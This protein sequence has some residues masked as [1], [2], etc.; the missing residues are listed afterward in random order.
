[1]TKTTIA[2]IVYKRIENIQRWLKCWAI[3]DQTDAE[4][5]VIHNFDLPEHCV[6]FRNLC[7]QYGVRYIGRQNIGYDIGAF[8]DMCRGKYGTFEQLLWIT[9]DTIPM[10]KDFVSHFQLTDGVGLKCMEISSI[11]S[12]LHVRTTGF[13]I[14]YDTAKKLRF[15][16]IRT[17]EDCYYFE[18]RGGDNTL[19]RQVELM[20]L[21][22][23]MVSKPEVSPLWDMQ[24]RAHFKRM[25]EHESEFADVEQDKVIFICCA[26]NNYPQI[27]SSLICQTY[28]N[29]ELYI[30]HDGPGT[31]DIPNDPRIHFEATPKRSGN[32]GHSIRAEWL[33]KLKDSGKYVVITN[34]DN[35]YM[36]EFVQ[37]AVTS[38]NSNPNA[39]AAYSK[40]IIHN[41]T[42]WEVMNCRLSRGF[43]DCGQVMLRNKEVAEIGWN[44]EHHSADW[45]FF[46]D[47]VAKYGA[48][49]FVA[50][51]GCHFVHN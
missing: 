5:I 23:E 8:Q 31:L 10:S 25:K 42:G 38:L 2:I 33:Q 14:S 24:Q 30:V 27:I 46:A 17:K 40:Q 12:P 44:S 3:S 48:Q 37:R 4:L 45:F 43:I 16:T 39:I 19:M 51:N 18:H 15:P 6:A 35:Y 29:W 11:R 36:P 1:M 28:K 7:K 49:S 32:Y 26:Y 34:A 47:I 41:Y 21:K 9:D 50:F 13:C 22:C 20:G